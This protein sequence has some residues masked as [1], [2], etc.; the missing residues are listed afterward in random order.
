[1]KNSILILLALILTSCNKEQKVVNQKR[2]TLHYSVGNG[3]D[4]ITSKI[5]CDSFKMISEKEC[6]YYVDG[7]KREHYRKC[8]NS[9]KYCNR[10]KLNSYSP[11]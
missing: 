6:I 9:I 8:N 3:W 4:Y 10:R 11:I 2:F 5:E 1:M 7:I